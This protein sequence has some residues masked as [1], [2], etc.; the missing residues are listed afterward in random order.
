MR[1]SKIK[2][3]HGRPFWAVPKGGRNKDFATRKT[4]QISLRDV[5]GQKI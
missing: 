3:F 1:G 5:G 4:V 2:F